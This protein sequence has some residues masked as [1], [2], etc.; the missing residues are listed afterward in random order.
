MILRDFLKS[1]VSPFVPRRS[2]VRF[3]PTSFFAFGTKRRRARRSLAPPPRK[4]SRLLRLLPCKRGRHASAALPTFCGQ[5]Q[6]LF[7]WWASFAVPSPV[8]PAGGRVLWCP[9][10]TPSHALTL[11]K[12]TAY[13]HGRGT[14]LYSL[15]PKG[16][17]AP[18]VNPPLRAPSQS[19]LRR[20]SS[21]RGR[22]K[23]GLF[24]GLTFFD[25]HL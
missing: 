6:G 17:P 8:S 5:G 2:K 16:A 25:C 23:S 1:S 14:V 22:A 18:F 11:Q 24:S 3:A 21:P 19:R 13:R 10:P 12:R 9:P 20:A 7:H 4:K 15:I